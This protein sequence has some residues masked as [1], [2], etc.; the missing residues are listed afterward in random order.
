MFCSYCGEEVGAG[1]KF[2]QKCGRELVPVSKE[3][4]THI[5]GN[6]TSV[7][8]DNFLK[9]KAMERTTLFEPKAAKAK[10]AK[11]SPA[12]KPRL[13]VTINTGI[14]R[15]N[16]EGKLVKCR[17]KTLPLKVT[18]KA[19]KNVIL[20]AAVRKHTAFDKAFC[21][22]SKYVLLYPDCTEVDKTPGTQKDF[23]LDDYGREI[24]R[25]FR[26]ITLFIAKKTDFTF[27][28]IS[29][30]DDN[31]FD[32]D[33]EYED[34]PIDNYNSDETIDF[35]KSVLSYPTE[36]ATSQP[37]SVSG[38]GRKPTVQKQTSTVKACC[39]YN[40]V[41]V[42]IQWKSSPVSYLLFALLLD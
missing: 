4:P 32:S 5:T 40:F 12:A 15:L 29:P 8:L 33:Q 10:I 22:E 17:G 2:C 9:R 25:A 26:R 1:S 13:E 16:S 21:V 30:I 6:V 11:S 20:E 7:S 41:C 24:G 14:M 42:N 31:I 19:S 18:T 34:D 3:L 27:S 23:V 35:E 36:V 39:T 28:E 38:T 37:S